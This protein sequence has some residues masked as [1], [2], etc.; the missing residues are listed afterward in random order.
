M[1]LKLFCMG[2]DWVWNLKLGFVYM[3]W[4][5]C[6]IVGIWLGWEEIVAYRSAMNANWSKKVGGDWIFVSAIF[7]RFKTQWV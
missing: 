3:D 4:E 1:C 2:V 5:L 6:E 7:C